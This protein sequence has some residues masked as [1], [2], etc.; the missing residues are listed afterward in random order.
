L[1]LG[2]KNVIYNVSEGV[3]TV[4]V[5]IQKDTVKSDYVNWEIKTIGEM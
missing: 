1:N 2:E 4:V 5:F 3:R